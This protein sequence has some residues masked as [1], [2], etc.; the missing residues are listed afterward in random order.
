MRIRRLLLMSAVSTMVL[1]S[2]SASRAPVV[3]GGDCDVCDDNSSGGVL[4]GFGDRH[5]KNGEGATGGWYMPMHGGSNWFC[6]DCTRDSECPGEEGPGSIHEE[7]GGGG[8]GSLAAAVKSG[9]TDALRAAVS[10]KVRYVL[11]NRE[12]GMLALTNCKGV[13]IEQYKLSEQQIE[14]ITD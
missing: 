8:G 9:D 12:L 1:M 14:A 13:P 5:R 4:C 3:A 2:T 11:V 10:H 7:D 6:G